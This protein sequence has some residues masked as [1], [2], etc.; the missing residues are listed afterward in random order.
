MDVEKLLGIRAIRNRCAW[1]ALYIVTLLR[2]L[3]SLR[4]SETDGSGGASTSSRGLSN[5][6]TIEMSSHCSGP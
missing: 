1:E 3:F 6:L 5:M 4:Q 2:R